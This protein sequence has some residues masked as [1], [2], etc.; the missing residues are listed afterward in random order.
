MEPISTIKLYK[1]NAVQKRHSCVNSKTSQ[2]LQANRKKTHK[3][4]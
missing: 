3:T 2:K 4:K 1:N